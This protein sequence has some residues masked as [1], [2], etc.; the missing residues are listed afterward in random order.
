M[1]GM[2]WEQLSA[3]EIVVVA[4]VHLPQPRRQIH[5]WVRLAQA[6]EWRL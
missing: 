6:G 5:W 1:R 4:V 2:R 3:A